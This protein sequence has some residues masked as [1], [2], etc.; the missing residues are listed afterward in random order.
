M[1]CVLWPPDSSKASR[2]ELN[3]YKCVVVVVMVVVK[4]LESGKV[5]FKPLYEI[6]KSHRQAEPVCDFRLGSR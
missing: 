1:K 6:E 5:H 2:L 3:L 4:L